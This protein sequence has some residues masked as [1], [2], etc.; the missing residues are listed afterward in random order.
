MKFFFSWLAAELST[1]HTCTCI[2]LFQL[3][4][5]TGVWEAALS[6]CWGKRESLAVTTEEKKNG[7]NYKHI[8]FY[9]RHMAFV[10]CRGSFPKVFVILNRGK[11][12]FA[13]LC[14]KFCLHYDFLLCFLCCIM[15]YI[16]IVR[17]LYRKCTVWFGLYHVSR[18]QTPKNRTHVLCV[19]LGL[20]LFGLQ[21]FKKLKT[22]CT[23]YFVILSYKKTV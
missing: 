15:L 2:F 12:L 14:P 1:E 20:S 8:C 3:I 17:R 19:L 21:R 13:L 9:R 4:R 16:Q 11:I 23:V 10:Q 18:T 7:Q 6:Q 5:Q 22:Q